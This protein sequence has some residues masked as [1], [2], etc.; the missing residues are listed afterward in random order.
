M[1]VSAESYSPAPRAAVRVAICAAGELWGGVEQCVVTLARGLAAEGVP[2]H[3]LLFFE[4]RLA[5]ALR[6]AGIDTHVFASTSKYDRALVSWIR[7]ALARLGVN[8]LHVH[9][10]KATIVGGLA[11]RGTSIRVIKTE[12]GQIERAERWSDFASYSRLRM[13]TWLEHLMTRA[14]VDATAVVSGDLQRVAERRRGTRNV[15]LIYNGIEP[16]DSRDVPPPAWASVPGFHI[17]IVGRLETVKGHAYL[18]SA[19]ERLQHLRD[20]HVHVFGSGPL[21]HT[22][23]RWVAERHLEQRVRFHGFQH[24][25]H[26]HLRALH[27]LVMPSLHEGLPYAL[28]EAMQLGIPV[29]GSCV[30]GLAEVLG[31]GCGLLVEPRDAEGL[32]RAIQELYESPHLRLQLAERAQRKLSERFRAADMVRKYMGVY[33]ELVS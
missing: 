29:V 6:D 8:V 9:G 17:G 2:P 15:R 27:V 12:H 21:E 1:L 33:S 30:G 31:D 32:A 5:D 13:N 25:I 18:L 7:A 26:P 14:A 11:T 20:L 19:V 10:Y 16:P 24:P 23:R 3:A 28:L 22:C 4:G